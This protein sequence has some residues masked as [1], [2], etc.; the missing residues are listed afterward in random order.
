MKFQLPVTLDSATRK[1]D[2]SLSIRFSSNLE[3]S[4]EDYM[5]IDK[6]MQHTGWL[7]FADNEVQAQ[8]V[9]EIPADEA[10]GKMSPSQETRWLLKKLHEQQDS[11]ME[12][13]DY[14]RYQMSKINDKLK[15]LLE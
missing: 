15:G 5:V 3:V 13:P 12:W 7:V 4:T 2:K 11:D 1:R 9:P 10:Y 14:Y 6:V 8:E